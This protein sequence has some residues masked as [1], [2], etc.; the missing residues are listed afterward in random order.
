MRTDVAIVGAGPAGARAAYV[1]ARRGARVTVFDGSR[2]REKPCGGGVTGRALALVRDQI[3]TRHLPHTVIRSVRFTQ[4]SGV[5]IRRSPAHPASVF[6]SMRTR[7]WWRA[8]RAS[9]K[10]CSRP[11]RLPEPAS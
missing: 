8:G 3:D 10:R 9:M 7:W 6:R 1:L 2:P 5:P 4:G 11:P